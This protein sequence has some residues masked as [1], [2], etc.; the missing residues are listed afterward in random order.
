MRSIFDPANQWIGTAPLALGPFNKRPVALDDILNVPKDSGP[1]TVDVLANDFD[2]EGRPLSLVSAAAALGTAVA[3]PDDTVS[4][5]PPAGVTGSDTIVY[6]IADDLG[7]TRDGQVNVT[8]TQPQLSIDTQPDAT[9]TVNAE[10]GLIDI[11]VTDPPAFAGTYQADTADL[12]GGPVNLAPPAIT[13]SVAAGATLT[14]APGLWIYDTGAGLPV[15]SW[16]WRLAAADIVGATSDT[17]IVQPGDTGSGISVRE[18]QADNFGQRFA[19]SPP[20]AA[21]TPASD[22]ALIGWW[23][24]DDAATLSESGGLVSLWRDKAGAAD[25][26]QSFGPEQPRTGSRTLNGRNVVDFD[27]TQR[28]LAN[29]GLPASGD[30]AFHAALLIDGTASAFAAL[31]S[32]EAA[33]DFQIDA[34]SDTVF[35]GRLNMAGIGPSVT[36]TGGPFAGALVLSA[37]FD[38]TGAATA[39]VHVANQLRGS[40]G[41]T[42]PIDSAAALHLMSNRSLNANIDGAVA[43][44]IVTGDASNRADHHAYLAAKWGLV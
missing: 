20:A 17:Y 5:T 12:A 25:L 38:R 9:L 27:G 29:L 26:A 14:A 34:G 3:E 30:V 16:Q 23:D 43:E 31:L 32:I 35:D 21:F 4:Y 37:V 1:I 10:N 7:Q 15:R 2:P 44:L 36:L 6:T 33:N 42:A 39:E 8:I 28:M 18:A 24:A 22:A 41:Y 13:G 11:T 40:T 19:I